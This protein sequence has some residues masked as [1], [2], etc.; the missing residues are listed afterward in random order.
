MMMKGLQ[1]YGL[2]LVAAFAASP[3]GA[4]TVDFNT[5]QSCTTA[6]VVITAGAAREGCTHSPNGM[7]ATH[8]IK[9]TSF[10]GDAFWTA[11]F[12]A[13]VEDISVRMGDRTRDDDRLFLRAFGA[14]GSLLAETM[15]DSLGQNSL[16]HQLQL[17]IS[18]IASATFGVTADLGAGSGIYADDLTFT[19]R[20]GGTLPDTGVAP[21]PLPAAGVLLTVGLIGLAAARRKQ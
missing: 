18:G 7:D 1:T 4:V 10:R 19:V 21:V 17:N 2:G 5:V 11:V 12:T 20:A 3:A 15:T 6:E 16:N 14:D 13:P 9:R 8:A